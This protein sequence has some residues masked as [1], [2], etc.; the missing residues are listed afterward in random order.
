MHLGVNTTKISYSLYVALLWLYK[1][2]INYF[3]KKLSLPTLLQLSDSW[4]RD[5]LKHIGEKAKSSPNS[6]SETRQLHVEEWNSIFLSYT[7]Q[8]SVFKW[9]KGLNIMSGTLVKGILEVY[10][11]FLA[12]ECTSLTGPWFHRH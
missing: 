6:D 5:Q 8:N 12:Q 1:L 2:V 9:I 4:Q 10:L 3:K 7:T 11:T